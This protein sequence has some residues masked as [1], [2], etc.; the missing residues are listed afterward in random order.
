MYVLHY[1]QFNNNNE[2]KKGIKMQKCTS[3]SEKQ[4]VQVSVPNSENIGYDTVA[5]C[6]THKMHKKFNS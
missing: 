3:L 1:A 6:N 2:K 4:V 5:S